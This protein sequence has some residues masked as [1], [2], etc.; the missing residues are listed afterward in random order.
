MSEYAHLPETRAGD[1]GGVHTNG[2]ITSHAAYLVAQSLGGFTA[3]FG[4]LTS[5]A[6]GITVVNIDNGFGAAMAALSI[7]HAVERA[8]G[9]PPPAGRP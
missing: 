2:G 5:C 1:W 8:R 4:M 7:L 3:L 6:S 9:G